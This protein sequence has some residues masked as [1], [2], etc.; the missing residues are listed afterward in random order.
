MRPSKR[1]LSGGGDSASGGRARNRLASGHAVAQSGGGVGRCQGGLDVEL[2]VDAPAAAGAV[3]AGG[4]SIQ[5]CA[6]MTVLNG[7]SNQPTGAT[8][9][10]PGQGPSEPGHPDRAVWVVRNDLIGQSLGEG[11]TV[12]PGHEGID[13]RVQRLIL[14]HAHVAPLT[15]EVVVDAAEE[16]LSRRNDAF[17]HAYRADDRRDG[18]P[19][20]L[21]VLALGHVVAVIISDVL[22]VAAADKV[23]P[24]RA[25]GAGLWVGAAAR[26]QALRLLRTHTCQVQTDDHGGGAQM[27]HQFGALIEVDV[28]A[29]GLPVDP[30]SDRYLQRTRARSLCRQR[31]QSVPLIEPV[32]LTAA[33]AGDASDERAGQCGFSLELA[34]R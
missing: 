26:A 16:E 19:G 21:A 27:P 34:G 10:M 33:G 31:G 7:E 8:R 6:H 3:G 11:L 17:Q 2:T 1:G 4:A 29:P 5:N 30:P 24:G 32:D 13:P 22:E 18:N 20:N 23:P 25:V 15:V 14:H 12:H 9:N 28:L